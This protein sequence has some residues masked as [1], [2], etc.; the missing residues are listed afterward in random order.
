MALLHLLPSPSQTLKFE[1]RQIC[2]KEQRKKI[3]CVNQ[4]LEIPKI[5][6]NSTLPWITNP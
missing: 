6:H 3:N 4:I 1:S 2:L 5:A